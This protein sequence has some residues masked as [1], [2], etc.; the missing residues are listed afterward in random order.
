MTTAAC[1]PRALQLA[2][3]LHRSQQP[4]VTILFGSRA[5]G[6]YR[7]DS[8]IDILFVTGALPASETREQ[9]QAAAAQLA[10]ARYQPPVPVQLIWR[11]PD[12]YDQMR[13]T[14][15]HFIARAV[16]EGVIMPAAAVPEPVEPSYEWS[17]TDE[18]RRHARIHLETFADL[19]G[20]GAYDRVIGQNAQQAMEHALKA[21]ISAAGARYDR[22]HNLRRLLAQAN[23]AD[24][25]FNFQPRS[26]YA[27]LGQYAGHDDYYNPKDP[28]TT[29]PNYQ[30]DVE[31]D[32]TALLNR[33]DQLQPPPA[34]AADDA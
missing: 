1:D 17:V 5:R 32:V 25:A 9:V 28:I 33:A 19:A 8:D 23:A 11:T 13:R 29:I 14:R 16:D 31:A 20:R 24:P 12:E 15:N 30:A 22:T 21:H 26:D 4:E 18:R 10:D 34:P 6:D 2:R 3:A 27:A 7:P